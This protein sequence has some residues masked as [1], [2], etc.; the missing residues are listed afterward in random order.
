MRERD[1]DFARRP[2]H[3]SSEWPS[4]NREGGEWGRERERERGGGKVGD[5]WE[6]MRETRG[7]AN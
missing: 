7:E 2:D 6:R 1:R 5:W 3:K 4:L